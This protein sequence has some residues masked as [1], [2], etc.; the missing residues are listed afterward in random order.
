MCISLAYELAWI[1]ALF[2][3]NFFS[4]FDKMFYNFKCA[5]NILQTSLKKTKTLERK[6]YV[7]IVQLT[8]LINNNGD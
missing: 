3:K 5:E 7:K 2:K 4:K 6:F 8:L 1:Y